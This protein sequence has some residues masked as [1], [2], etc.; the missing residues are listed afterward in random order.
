MH[1]LNEQ[2]YKDME[3]F[4][5]ETELQ[6]DSGG[7]YE[8]QP[9]E[10]R[11][12]EQSVIAFR[13]WRCL[14]PPSRTDETHPVADGALW[15]LAVVICVYPVFVVATPWIWIVL[16][17]IQTIGILTT[18]SIAR[19]MPAEAFVLIYRLGLVSTGLLL[20]AGYWEVVA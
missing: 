1:Q 12:V 9:V 5:P 14:Y 20:A 11:Q 15:V 3:G 17:I 6:P 19:A 8:D 7:Y 4:V 13:L 2:D 18:L 16:G 10:T